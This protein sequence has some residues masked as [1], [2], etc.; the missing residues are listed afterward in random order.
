MTAETTQ[1]FGQKDH[2]SPKDHPGIQETIGLTPETINIDHSVLIGT[3]TTA[4]VHPVKNTSNQRSNEDLY[5]E[6]L[7]FK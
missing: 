3:E 5:Q 4:N 1:N 6:T 2:I 7:T